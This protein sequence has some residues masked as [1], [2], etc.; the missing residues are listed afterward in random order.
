MMTHAELSA[1]AAKLPT[2]PSEFSTAEAGARGQ[3]IYQTQIRPL[4]DTEEN[5]GKL[6]SVDI[7]SGDYEMSDDFNHIEAVFC[8]RARQPN[9]VVYT[10]RIGYAAAFSRGRRQEPLPR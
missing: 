8:L 7:L 1:A 5:V 3:E 10:L 2:G 4:V 9:A 6:L